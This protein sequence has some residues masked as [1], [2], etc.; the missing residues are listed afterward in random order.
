VHVC[1]RS[2]LGVDR[3]LQVTFER[4]D[5]SV[6]LIGE[7]MGRYSNV[8]LT[9]AS[10]VVL[11]ALKHIH[12]G[13]N[14]VRV[15]LPRH[16]YVPPPQPMQPS[17][18]QERPK[19]DPFG[20]IAG[21]LASVLPRLA[22][23][24]PLCKALVDHVDG[25]SPVLA[26]EVTFLVT[27]T[28][29]ATT[30]EHH[31]LAAITATMRLIR[32]RFSPQRGQPCAIRQGERLAD[33][34]AFPLHYYGVEPALYPDIAA[35]LDDVF[36][37]PANPMAGQKGQVAGAIEAA[38][39]IARRK[40]ASLEAALVD[41]PKIAALRTHGEMVLAYQHGIAPGQPTLSVPELDLEIPLDVA[42][43]PVENAQRLFKQ[44]AKARDAAAIVPGLL[45]G[46]RHEL[47][48][49]DQLA[50]HAELA[51]DPQS[52]AA[53]RSE[54]REF[55]ASPE[56]LAR[57]TRKQEKQSRGAKPQHGKPAVSPLRVRAADGT[58]IL[59]GRSAKQNDAVTFRMAGP[60]DIWF[61]ARQIPGAHVILRVGGRPPAP[62]T[63]LQA[64]TLAAMHSQAR[65]ST[66]V[67]VDYTEVRHV[68]RIK[69]ARPGLVHYSGE[70][71]INVRPQPA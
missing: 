39:K 33:Y 45:E 54:L 59:V 41:E 67:P 52:L 13:E 18:Q 5:D 40:I 24:T 70:T 32:D 9:D 61:H 26:R 51:G 1:A 37:T 25:V 23:S 38:R 6:T 7:V 16:P 63:L 20:S 66:T 65:S 55:S 44:Y 69:G 15:T 30:G 28:I 43:T 12:A 49:L 3:V 68:R 34:A 14:R 4:G 35:L 17:P 64:A 8:I 58:E 19:L 48:Y 46:A 56:E 57:Q 47:E 29:T 71:T 36:A 42:L 27:G 22:P 50:V 60:R 21:D 11:G 31:D 10:M 62:D 2:Q 53:V